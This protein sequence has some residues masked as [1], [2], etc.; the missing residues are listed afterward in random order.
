MKRY[1]AI[2]VDD[3][4]DARETLNAYLRKYCK[5]VKIVA[6]AKNIIEA[7]KEIAKHNPDILFLD[8]EMPFGNAFDLL[9]DLKKVDFEIIFITAFSQ[10]ALQ[11]LNMSAAHYLLK[12]IDIDEL[13]DAVDKTGELLEQKV[14][15][16]KIDILL[17]NLKVAGHH[18]KK[19]VLPQLNG[20]EVKEIGDIV[21]CR[22]EDN[23]TQFYF[24]DSSKA[25]ICRNLKYYEGLF[26][27]MGFCRIH[28]S[29]LINLE[30]VQKYQKG[31][32]GQVTLS[33]GKTLDVS[34]S[35]KKNF[36]EK[37]DLR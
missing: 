11:A 13:I 26:E 9:S 27:S 25:L 20:F 31:R 8:I 34:E 22:A 32:G 37:F 19:I 30:Y 23:Y 18:N 14:K 2:I 4:K 16:D 7:K 6:E 3:E 33:T 15:V 28:R 35:K 10:Y 1:N 17:E 21:Y 5:S 29:T 12:P 36:L 24:K